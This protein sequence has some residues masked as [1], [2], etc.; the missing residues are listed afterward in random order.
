M[1]YLPPT[2]S[3]YIAA[4]V[5]V[6]G[7]QAIEVD[8]HGRGNGS[9]VSLSTKDTM[10]SMHTRKAARIYVAAWTDAKAFASYLPQSRPVQV[11]MLAARQPGLVVAAHGDDE[12]RSVFNPS[13]NL[14]PNERELR[15]RIGYMTW[16]VLDQEAFG[17]ML[18]GWAKVAKLAPVVLPIK[19]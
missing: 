17:S 3:Q 8:A 14:D 4:T 1:A 18:D 5:I 12:V 9:Y 6:T 2:G 16:V 10:I 19:K 15:I 13:G 11:E 7:E